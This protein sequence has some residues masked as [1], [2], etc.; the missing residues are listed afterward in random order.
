MRDSAT[1]RFFLRAYSKANLALAERFG[2]ILDEQIAASTG[3]AIARDPTLQRLDVEAKWRNQKQDKQFAEQ[4][5]KEI[6]YANSED[7]LRSREERELANGPVWTGTESVQD[8][9]LRMLMDTVPKAKSVK[10]S[11]TII[12]PPVPRVARVKSAKETSLDYKVG[13]TLTPEEKEREDFKEMYKER[14]LGPLMFVDTTSSRATMG[15]VGSMADARINEAIDSKTGKFDSPEMDKVRGKPLD[16]ERLAN[17]RDTNF[18]VNHIL[19]NQECLPPWIESQQGIDRDI[20]GFRRDLQQMWFKL[21]MSV[22]SDL[23]K[24]EV[25]NALAQS[26]AREMATYQDKF[27]ATNSGYITAKVE[28]LN[29]GVRNYNLQCPSGS[30]H[31]WKVVESREI[32]D[33]FNAVI[34][35]INALVD[36]WFEMQDRARQLRAKVAPPK[37]SGF[38][39]F[40]SSGLSSLG[41]GTPYMIVE[42]P[43]EKI[44]FWKLMKLLFLDDDVK[45]R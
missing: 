3:S 9:A 4:Y 17:S 8:T 26:N 44:D 12:S 32:A 41:A 2:Q 1:M 13:K 25:L 23:S 20:A 29:H 10:Q 35:N 16:R 7:R 5:Q 28:N 31:K 15:L 36:E 21:I 37:K 14:L 33:L 11:K 39:G 27:L 22:F 42:R 43:A 19:T 38:A 34:D 30:L 18:F 24:L 6:G 45:H 40:E